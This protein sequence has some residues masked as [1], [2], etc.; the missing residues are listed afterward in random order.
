MFFLFFALNP[1]CKIKKNFLK[2][3]RD[4]NKTIFPNAEIIEFVIFSK[5]FFNSANFFKENTTEMQ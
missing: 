4:N 3:K 1:N 5:L 2:S